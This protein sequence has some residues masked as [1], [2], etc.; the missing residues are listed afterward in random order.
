MGAALLRGD[1][2]SAWRYNPVLLVAC[3]LV[4]ARAVGWM[5]EWARHPA[6]GRRW[7]PREVSEH[8]LGISF[9]VGIGWTIVRNLI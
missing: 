5:V 8:A 4:A 7:L 2:A 6:Y 9:I 1:L 3:L